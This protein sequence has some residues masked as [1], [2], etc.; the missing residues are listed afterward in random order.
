MRS[1]CRAEGLHGV[2]CFHAREHIADAGMNPCPKATCRC[3]VGRS[4]SK[5]SGSGNIVSSR[6]A[7]STDDDQGRSGRKRTTT[8]RRV[9][10]DAAEDGR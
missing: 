3:V 5:R 7:D 2:A 10:Q 9:V 8:E 6:F 4:G 1:T